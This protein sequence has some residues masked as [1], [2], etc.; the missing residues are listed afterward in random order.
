ML[1]ENLNAATGMTLSPLSLSF[2]L[3]SLSHTHSDTHKYMKNEI[4]LTKGLRR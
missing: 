3:P 2:S 4:T 1:M